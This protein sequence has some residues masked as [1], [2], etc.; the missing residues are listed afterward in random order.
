MWMSFECVC[1]WERERERE[2]EWVNNVRIH[3]AKCLHLQN[4]TDL[5]ILYEWYV[6]DSES[7]KEH[8]MF[9]YTRTY[10][11]VEQM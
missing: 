8:G 3:G 9:D 5:R 1:V 11:D 4:K 10:V 7:F 6:N 2:I